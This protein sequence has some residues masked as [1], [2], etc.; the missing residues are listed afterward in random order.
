[1][2]RGN[3]S[4]HYDREKRKEKHSARK[5]RQNAILAKIQ[6]TADAKGISELQNMKFGEKVR[7]IMTSSWILNAWY[8]KVGFLL[9]IIL[10]C[11]KILNLFGLF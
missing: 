7:F 6:G 10:G 9:F 8:E 11:W 4:K 3:V 1:M 5:A 2:G